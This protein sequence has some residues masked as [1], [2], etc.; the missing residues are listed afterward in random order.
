MKI[1]PIP[2]LLIWILLL[3]AGL[4]MGSMIATWLIPVLFGKAPPAS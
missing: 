1:G 3:V 4:L 2:L